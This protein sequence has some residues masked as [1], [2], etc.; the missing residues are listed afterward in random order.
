MGCRAQ[1]YWHKRKIIYS[2]TS[3]R[4]SLPL[5]LSCVQ[6]IADIIHEKGISEKRKTLQCS[7]NIYIYIY[8]YIV[9]TI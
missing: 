3:D 5:H 1:K 4:L 9:V 2:K 7:L 6:N 8:I